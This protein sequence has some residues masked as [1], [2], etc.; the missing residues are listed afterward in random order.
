MNRNVKIGIF[1]LIALI[2]LCLGVNYLKGADM[3]YRGKKLYAIYEDVDGLGDASPILFSGYKIGKVRNIDVYSENGEVRFCATLAIEV[4]IDIPSDSRAIVSTSGILGDKC[5]ILTK[6]SSDILAKSGDTI[7]SGLI[8]SITE[9]LLPIKDKAESFIGHADTTIV[10]VNRLLSGENGRKLDKAIESMTLAMQ[11]FEKA[12]R[13]IAMMT[14]RQGSLGSTITDLH[15]LSESLGRQS[16]RIDSIMI[17]INQLTR[18]LA[19]S[20][21]TRH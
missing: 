12:S 14:E 17:N 4:P 21:S 11:N 19:E 16:S 8:T 7:Q 1:A 2:I 6:G 3:L 18:M 10:G 20:K 5:V 13:N 15:S 9:Q